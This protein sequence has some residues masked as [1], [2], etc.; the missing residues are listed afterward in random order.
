[1]KIWGLPTLQNIT[2]FEDLRRFVT[3]S[4][5]SMTQALSSNLTFEDNFRGAIFEVGPLGSVQWASPGPTVVSHGL[6]TIPTGFLV[7]GKDAAGDVSQDPT[8]PATNGKIFLNA[9]V[10]TTTYRIIILG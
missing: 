8:F 5:G 1:M 6:N 7:I 2:T 9:S 3:Q 4:V 10:L